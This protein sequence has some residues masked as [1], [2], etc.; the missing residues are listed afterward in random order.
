MTTGVHR[1]EH[2][3]AD[4]LLPVHDPFYDEPADVAALA[5]PGDIIR[6]RQVELKD[7][8]ASQHRTDAWQLLYRSTDLRGVAGGVA[9]TTVVLPRRR[10]GE[11]GNSS[12]CRSSARSMPSPRR[13][14]RR[15]RCER[16]PGRGGTPSHPSNSSWCVAHLRRAGR[17]PS[18]TTRACS[19]PGGALRES[20]DIAPS[21]V[22]ARRWPSPITNSHT[23]PP[24]DCGGVT[25]VAVWRRRGL[26]RWRRS[27]HR[28]CGWSAPSSDHRSVTW[29]RRSC[30]STGACMPVCPSW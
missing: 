6:C 3:P 22:S 26:R 18:P 8:W 15:T 10:A 27:M 5:P 21:T 16:V 9:A 1:G 14:S 17:S 23:T 29:P 24:S 11:G 25:P 12:C 28:N 19:A 4:V 30:D 20:P 7:Y 13:V 2:E